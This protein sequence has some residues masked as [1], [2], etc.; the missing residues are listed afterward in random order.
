MTGTPHRDPTRYLVAPGD[1]VRAV[2][3]SIDAAQ[4]GF[5]L[6]ATGDRRLLGTI[7]DGDL[8]RA[9]LDGFDIDRPVDDLLARKRERGHSPPV[10]APVGTPD[11]ALLA[12]MNEHAIRHVPLVDGDG[13][14]AAVVAM[15]DLLQEYELPLRAIV[16]AGGYGT[17]LRPLTESVPKPMLPVGEGP[18]LERIVRQLQQAGIRRVNLAT[19]YKAD[20]IEQHF[21]DGRQFDVDIA[22]VTEDEPLGTAGALRLLS[23]SDEPILVMNGDIVTR[24]DFRAMLDFHRAHAADMTVAVRSLDVPLPYGVVRTNGV[25]VVGVLEKPSVTY[26]INAGLYLL[27]ADVCALVPTEGPYHMTDL[28]DRTIAHGR[29]VVSFP[30]REYWRDIGGGEDYERAMEDVQKGKA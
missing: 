30:I 3:A 7:S 12:L 1:S 10:T 4:T 6:V 15:V 29:R 19:H 27:N 18:L 24:V 26:L 13:C 25:D 8:R 22:Y 14:V 16:M 9:I 2:T 21:G 28:I 5:A 23:A 20:V 11:P 17:R